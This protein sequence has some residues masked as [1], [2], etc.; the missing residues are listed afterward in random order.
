MLHAP[1][2]TRLL[3]VTALPPAG[4]GHVV[5]E[6]E[7]AVDAHTA[8][9]LD[10][11]LATQTRRSGLA[12]LTVDMRR[13]TSLAAAGIPV[14]ARARRRCRLRGAR[15]AVVPDAQGRVL[16]PLRAC[17]LDDLL[18]GSAGAAPAGSRVLPSAAPSRNGARQSARR[19]RRRPC[20]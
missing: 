9:L 6:V 16:R 4:P 1:A 12:T 17:G 7:G 8:P 13:V 2:R 11:C 18:P 10:A 14:L 20:R 3:T 15:L 5:V 19:G